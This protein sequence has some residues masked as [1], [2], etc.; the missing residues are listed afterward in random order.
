[1]LL[2][3]T[4][5]LFCVLCPNRYIRKVT[6]PCFHS[7]PHWILQQRS[8]NGVSSVHFLRLQSVM[9]AVP[10]SIVQK[11]KFDPITATIRNTLHWLLM[12]QAIV[13]AVPARIQESTWLWSDLSVGTYC[14]AFRQLV[15]SA[16]TVVCICWRN[17][18]CCRVQTCP[19]HYNNRSFDVS[20]P[21]A[22]NKFLSDIHKF[23]PFLFKI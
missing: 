13:Q 9:N 2:S 8:H 7:L 5:A 17:A 1:M 15:S 12:T 23:R 4:A 20:G 3:A 21:T 22:W 6:R 19:V 18:T 14:T 11:R 16:L 10:C